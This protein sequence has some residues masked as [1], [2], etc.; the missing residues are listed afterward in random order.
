MAPAQ[1]R[2][3]IWAGGKSFSWKELAEV[4]SY[5]FRYV[6]DQ[7]QVGIIKSSGKQRIS[8]ILWEVIGWGRFFFPTLKLEKILVLLN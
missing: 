4:G 2:G 6:F 5:W 1:S 3:M 7:L 8:S